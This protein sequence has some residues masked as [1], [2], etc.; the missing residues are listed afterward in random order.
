MNLNLTLAQR[1]LDLTRR[2]R[3]LRAQMFG[4]KTCFS[5]TKQDLDSDP[6]CPHCGFR[7]IEE[8]FGGRRAGD[9]ITKLDAQ[10]DELVTNW[11]NLLLSNLEDPTVASNIDLLSHDAGRK[12]IESFRKKRVLPEPV[13]AALVKALQEVLQGLER[14]VLREAELRAA[15]IEGGTPCTLPE[16]KQRFDA[17]VAALT[18]GKDPA[19]VRL[20]V[21]S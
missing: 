15:L 18:K 4:L 14:V 8:P 11:T 17:F 6:I 3:R 16:L 1:M 9:A 2:Q 13:P 10:L 5:L 12:A 21:E 19:R 20:V 7:P